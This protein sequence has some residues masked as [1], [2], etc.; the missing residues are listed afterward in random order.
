MHSF[1][2]GLGKSTGISRER[3]N[4]IKKPFENLT[5]LPAMATTQYKIIGGGMDGGNSQNFDRQFPS[6]P[7]ILRVKSLSHLSIADS[8]HDAVTQD[9]L[10]RF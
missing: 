1:A 7:P 5:H 3:P 9:A 10:S 6:E 4:G 8:F 2:K